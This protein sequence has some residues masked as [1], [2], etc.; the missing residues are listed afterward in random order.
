LCIGVAHKGERGDEDRKRL[1]NKAVVS[2]EQAQTSVLINFGSAWD[3]W[4]R[5]ICSVK[6]GGSHVSMVD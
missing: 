2:V 3:S 5:V 6:N 4:L 1:R